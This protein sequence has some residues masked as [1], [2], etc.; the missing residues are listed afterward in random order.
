MEKLDAYIDAHRA[1][2]DLAQREAA[3]RAA[4]ARL[5]AEAAAQRLGERLGLHRVVLFGSLVRGR[6]HERSDI[7]LAVEGLRD[8]ALTDAMAI[9]EED[10][11]F[12]FS[13]VPIERARD[14]IR[15]AIEREGLQL[16]P[17]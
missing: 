7:D 4:E 14:Y 13:I 10:P 2:R 1:R 11:R 3:L 5:A 16:W 12:E 15:D 6:F 9:A 8:G 17:R